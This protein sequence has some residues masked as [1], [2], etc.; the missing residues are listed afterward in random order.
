[1][2]DVTIELAGPERRETLE[3]L[4]QLYV[5]D[6]SDFLPGP[7][8]LR[9]DGRFSTEARLSAYWHA[10]DCDVLFIRA[11]GVLAG[12]AVVNRRSYSGEPYDFSMAEFFVARKFRRAGVGKTA[13]LTVIGARGPVGNR[14]RQPQPTGSIV[15]A[16]R[17]GGGRGRTVHRTQPP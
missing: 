15:L 11:D 17:C 6:F 4:F 13:A 9:E 10:P 14:C 16:Q 7:F 12:F 2:P 8:D 5:H 1:V 3:N